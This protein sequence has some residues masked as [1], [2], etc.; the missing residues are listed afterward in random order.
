MGLDSEVL[1]SFQSCS[2]VLGLGELKTLSG[3]CMASS[4]RC[5]TL[6]EDNVII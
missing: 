2:T 5:N 1:K 4:E 6:S 3:F